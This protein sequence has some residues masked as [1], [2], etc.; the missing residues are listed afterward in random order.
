MLNLQINWNKGYLNIPIFISGNKV[1]VPL[2]HSGLILGISRKVLV[3]FFFFSFQSH[4]LLVR[5][6]LRILY[7][8]LQQW[9]GF[10]PHYMF[11]TVD[12]SESYWFLYT[13]CTQPLW[14]IFSWFSWPLY[15]ISFFIIILFGLWF[16]ALVRTF[17]TM[18]MGI[19]GLL[20]CSQ[21]KQKIFWHVTV[22]YNGYWFKAEDL[23]K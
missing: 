12:A 14:I 10:F 19:Q 15:L 8:L 5:I 3:C 4:I 2:V 1:Y 6:I 18:L 22:K 23:I 17:R 21:N 7:L 13:Y 16:I 9:M 11:L 20:M